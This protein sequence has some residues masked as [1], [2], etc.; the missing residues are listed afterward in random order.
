MRPLYVLPVLGVALLTGVLAAYLWQIG[1]GKDIREIPSVLIDKP[2]PSFEL[3]PLKGSGKP[4]LSTADLKKGDTVLVSF[5]ASWCLPCKIEHPVLM[6][7]ARDGVRIV[8]IIYKDSPADSLR[9]LNELG[10]PY[11]RIGVDPKSRTAI[12]WGVSGVPE[13]FILDGRG[14]I[15]YRHVGPIHP[16]ELEEK[17]MPVLEAL[18]K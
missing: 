13:T 2:A 16:F 9:W 6:R 15:R 18:K 8:G 5:F 11:K 7:L 3:A 14:R 12:D 4:G 17:I 1:S 10:N